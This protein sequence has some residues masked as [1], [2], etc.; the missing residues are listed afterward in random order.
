MINATGNRMT[1][2]ITRQS[3]LADRI[4]ELQIQ[5]S[6]GKRLQ[7]ASDDPVAARRIATIGIAQAS[8]TTWAANVAS[9]SAQVSQA[10]AALGSISNLLIR[11]RELALSAASGTMNSSD[12]ASVAAELAGIADEIDGLA[13]SRDANGE[14]LFAVGSAK[15]IR[16]DADISFAPVPSAADAFVVGGNPL[17]TGLRDA[18]AAIASGDTPAINATLDT[19]AASISHVADQRAAVGLAAGRLERIGEGLAARGIVLADERSTIEDTDLSVAIAQLHATNLTLEAAQ[20]SFAR[21][22]RQTLFDILG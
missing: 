11:A 14:A 18:A 17:S 22:N 12:R 1:R 8:A 9:A 3:Q 4:N 15:I 16:F 20:A 2:E 19:L 6:S 21:I 13:A 5:V 7:R 10:D